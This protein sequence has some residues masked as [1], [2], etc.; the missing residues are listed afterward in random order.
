MK[1]EE[2]SLKELSSTSSTAAVKTVVLAAEMKNM[3]LTDFGL[4]RKKALSQ[5]GMR[6]KMA[7]EKATEASNND[8]VRT[9]DHITAIRYRV[10][11]TMLES[12]VEVA[13]E[14]VGT[15]GDLSSLSVKSALENALPESEQ[16]LQKLHSLPDVQ[17]NFKVELE[18][19]LLN[20]K[21]RFGKEER[22]KIISAVCQ[23]NRAIYDAAQTAD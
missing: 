4:A 21:G 15:A 9:F 23:V 6:L 5:A 8:A 18:E 7:R 13:L 12:A 3:D 19:S 11:A 2:E 10:M 16:C 1:I 22:R 20:V 17:N 14:T